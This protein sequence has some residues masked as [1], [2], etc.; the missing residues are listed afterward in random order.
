[1]EELKNL[2]ELFNHWKDAQVHNEKTKE[3]MSK[4]KI[5]VKSFCIDG[6]VDEECW[7][8]GD[9]ILFVLREANGAHA[10]EMDGDSIIVGN[11]EGKSFWIKNEIQSK[12][13]KNIPVMLKK[14]ENVCFCL[15]E[16]GVLKNKERAN[17]LKQSAFMNINKMGGYSSVHWPTLKKY[18]EQFK[19]YIKREIEIIAP[20]II[21]CCGT[22]WL[23]KEKVYSEEEWKKLRCKCKIYDLPH[24][25]KR[26]ISIRDYGR[27]EIKNKY[28]MAREEQKN[29]LKREDLKK[30]AEFIIDKLEDNLLD[31]FKEQL[32]NF[33]FG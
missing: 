6:Y 19:D 3:Y 5:S 29:N 13:E 12:N 28:N 16:A 24:P 14:L 15:Q 11:G 31:E 26:G 22:E 7:E 27:N 4:R 10:T 25:A 18:A 17:F 8:R 1:M 30:Q 20:E 32:D 21:V 9:K 33:K 2:R 23:L